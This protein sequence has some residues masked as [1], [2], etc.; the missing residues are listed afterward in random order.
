[1]KFPAIGWM[2]DSQ[3]SQHL[4]LQ[5]TRL[6]NEKNETERAIHLLEMAI[7][8]NDKNGDAYE[9]L[10]VILGH[11][12]KYDEAIELMAKLGEINPL[13][14]MAHSNLSLFYM[15]KGEI[16]RAEE[17]KAKATVL[18]M[19]LAGKKAKEQKQ[20]E[21]D[22]AKREE[23]YRQVLVLDPDDSYA[24]YN[25]ALIHFERNEIE[26]AIQYVERALQANQKDP[27]SYLLLG[28]ALVRSGQLQRAKSIYE[29]GSQV[30]ASQGNTA[31][32]AEM[33]EQ[34]AKL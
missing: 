6:Y 2:D 19:K 4:F 15:K 13:S 29:E 28:K 1:M 12:E 18:G 25:L 26:Q 22:V 31:L 14:V 7:T 23:M 11:Q 27:S 33:Q 24:N 20:R 30:A 17:E 34:L 21:Q 10:G 8:L 9:A 5:A 16:E 32:A 3:L